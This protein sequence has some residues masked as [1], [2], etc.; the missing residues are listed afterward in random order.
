VELEGSRGEVNWKKA[1]SSAEVAG[2]GPEGKAVQEEGC[3]TTSTT[4]AL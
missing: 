3:S 2:G 4:G 1:D